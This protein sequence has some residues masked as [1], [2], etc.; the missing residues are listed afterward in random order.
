MLSFFH[1]HSGMA[2]P[3]SPLSQRSTAFPHYSECESNFF[4]P[5][6]LF[7]YKKL[8]TKTNISLI[9][10][11]WQKPKLSFLFC[12]VHW[13]IFKSQYSL[14]FPCILFSSPLCL[15]VCQLRTK[16]YCFA[17]VRE[18]SCRVTPQTAPLGA[19]NDGFRF[20]LFCFVI[21]DKI[22]LLHNYHNHNNIVLCIV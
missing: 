6:W 3:V 20:L 16:N 21:L 12:S 4:L 5:F 9:L 19:A 1:S 18:S 22:A 8:R 2:S 17:W 11:A 14:Y 10:F 7:S 15:P 13:E